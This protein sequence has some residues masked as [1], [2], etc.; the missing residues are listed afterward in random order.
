MI[1][2]VEK[3]LSLFLFRLTYQVMSTHQSVPSWYLLSINRIAQHRQST[4]S[5]FVLGVM[6]DVM[7]SELYEFTGRKGP[8]CQV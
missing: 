5:N 6:K 4:N 3:R 8:M 7:F 1:V 2:L